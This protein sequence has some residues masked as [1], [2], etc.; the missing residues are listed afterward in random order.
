M[1]TLIKPR[2]SLM[3]ATVSPVEVDS[4]KTAPAEAEP[5]PTDSGEDSDG[6]FS[7]SGTSLDSKVL[8]TT[9]MMNGAAGCLVGAAASPKG[10]EGIWASIGFVMGA[11]LGEFGIVGVAL[12]AL[13]KKVG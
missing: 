6:I 2:L 1:Y 9:M 3:G 5:V 7:G 13:W 4:T 10:Q 8:A 11:T 12:A